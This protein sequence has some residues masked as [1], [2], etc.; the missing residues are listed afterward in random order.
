MKITGLLIVVIFV[1]ALFI[2]M[3]LI[4]TEQELRLYQECG[5]QWCR[6]GEK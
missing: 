4:G 3:F 5:G 6:V 1:E 2:W